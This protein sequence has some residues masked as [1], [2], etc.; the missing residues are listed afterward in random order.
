MKMEKTF[1][2]VLLIVLLNILAQAQVDSGIINRKFINGSKTE[3]RLVISSNN[4]SGEKTV[5]LDSITI[6]EEEEKYTKCRIFH[7]GKNGGTFTVE[8]VELIDE[9]IYDGFKYFT[10]LNEFGTCDEYAYYVYSVADEIWVPGDRYVNKHD[11]NGFVIESLQYQGG[12]ATDDWRLVSHE[13]FTTSADT[14]AEGTYIEH[15]QQVYDSLNSGWVNDLK[16]EYVYDLSGNL[17]SETTCSFDDNWEPYTKYAYAYDQSGAFT[18][19]TSYRVNDQGDGFEEEQVISLTNNNE[20]RPITILID[21]W[22]YQLGEMVTNSEYKVTYDEYGNFTEIMVEYF[23]DQYKEK[24]SYAYSADEM[25]DNI[26]E[27]QLT[28][29]SLDLHYRLELIPEHQMVASK[30]YSWDE[31][32]NNWVED[33]SL[34]YHYSGKT[35]SALP[36]DEL[37]DGIS[38][39]PNPVRKEIYITSDFDRLK[40][41]PITIYDWYGH[42]L[43]KSRLEAGKVSVESLEAGIYWYSLQLNGQTMYGKFLKK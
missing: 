17:L 37:D 7:E 38:V 15:I 12:A 6:E 36:V 22:D 19:I 35:L 13:F 14:N 21:K 30:S 31:D 23:V 27:A 11:E 40:G 32:L 34:T 3:S 29:S 28:T 10:K 39:Y 9:Q 16:Y 18:K 1:P 24:C 8:D 43:L 26:C 5:R 42:A 4:L 20:G 41:Q 2:V 33:A 25:W